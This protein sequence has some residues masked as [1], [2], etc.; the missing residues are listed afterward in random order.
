MALSLVMMS[1]ALVLFGMC[2]NI[3]D[4][5]HLDERFLPANLHI[6]IRKYLLYPAL[7]REKCSV[8]IQLTQG[9]PIDYVPPRLVSVAIFCYNVLNII[10]CAVPYTGFWEFQWY[11]HDTASLMYTY[12]GNRTGIL[13][14][15][16][17]PIMFMFASRNNIFQWLTGWSFATFQHFHRH[18]SIICIL[19]AFVH[20]VCYTIKFNKKPND[21]SYYAAEAA[22]GYFWWGIIATTACFIIPVFA[23]LKIRLT[24]YELF[25]VVHYILAILFL[26]GCAYHII[27]RY[28]NKWGYCYWLYCSYAVWGFDWFIRILRCCYLKFIK[29]YGCKATVELIDLDSRT[30]KITYQTTKNNDCQNCVG[31]YYY[32]YFFTLFPFFT[33]HPFTVSE[34][35]HKY[36]DISPKHQKDVAVA[37]NMAISNSSNKGESDDTDGMNKED[38]HTTMRN[39]ESASP[40]PQQSTISSESQL[41]FYVQCMNGTTNKIFQQLSKNDFKPIQIRSLLE[42]PYGSFETTSVFEDYDFLLILTGGIDYSF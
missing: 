28:H 12:V 25:L 1:W 6:W 3:I 26:L 16:N 41:V 14:F 32:L 10:F 21:A 13:S 30:L 27:L 24:S 20:S 5:F 29:G 42:G 23:V 38:D 22:K 9:F 33:S 2:Y 4:L 18:I 34:W 17:I 8:P 39:T 19:E 31:N 7:F 11:P 40:V 15:A 35:K 37:T 36:S